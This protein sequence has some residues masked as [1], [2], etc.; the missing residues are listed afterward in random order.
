MGSMI[1][2]TKTT[3]K[4]FIFE[5]KPL[6]GMDIGSDTVRVMQLD[7]IQKDHL[8]LRGYGAATFDPGAIKDGVIVKPELIA[9]AAFTL[10]H[11][12]LIGDINTKR[13]AVSLPASHAFTRAVRLPHMSAKDIADAVYAEAE[14]YIP[15]SID[16]LNL[17]YT[18]LREDKEGMEIF[19]VA[20]P[21]KIVDS[22]LMLTRMLGL[23][24]VLF[25]TTIGAS[26][27]LFSHDKQSDIPSVVVD[28]GSRDTDITV[29]NH[30]IVVT[31]SVAFGG[32]DIT[33][34]MVRALG[35]T[36][37]EAAMLKSEYG[38]TQSVVQK[39]VGV[40]LNPS[41]ALLV[42]EIRR[43]IRYYEQRYAKEPPI[44]QIVMTGGSANMPGLADYLTDQLRLPVRSLDLASHL[45]FGGLRPFLSADRT[46]YATVAGLATYNPG[47]V[48]A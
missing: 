15:G 44:G 3:S 43:T 27:Q 20:I 38:L 8:H 10:F 11:H 1:K 12:E 9:E 16:D 36:P 30:G 14:Q 29:F 39:Q 2:N 40:A 18:T 24:A 25:D 5:D 22:Y 26:A 33:T 42:K 47:E 35:V 23:E 37:H 28:F 7:K 41:L 45:D 32:E 19:L 4:V 34:T 17:D 6:F 46:S 48:F 13:V 21:K 31:G